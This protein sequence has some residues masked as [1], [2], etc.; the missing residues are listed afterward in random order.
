MLVSSIAEA[1][2]ALLRNAALQFDLPAGLDTPPP[3]M[4]HLPL[5]SGHVGLVWALA[6]AALIAIVALVVAYLRARPPPEPRSEAASG[7]VAAIAQGQAR[8]ALGDADRLAGQ[9]LYLEAAHALLACGV[10]A[11]A[12]RHPELLRPATTSRDIAGAT[13]LSEPLRLAFGRIAAAVEIGL[14]GGRA[15]GAEDY[16][17]CRRVFVD[18]ALARPA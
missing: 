6:G 9:G 13:A 14:F 3:A 10:D 2:A 11:I 5:G 1:H 17:A 7:P 4:P 8:A 18:S 12:D 15:V 16:A